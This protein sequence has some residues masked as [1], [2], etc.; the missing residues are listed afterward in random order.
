MTTQ[1]LRCCFALAWTGNC[2]LLE[3]L[4]RVATLHEFARDSRHK[5]DMSKTIY[6]SLVTEIY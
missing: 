2:F 6:R 5:A 3:V 4:T 1:D